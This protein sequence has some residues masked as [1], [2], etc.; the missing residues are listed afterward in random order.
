MVQRDIVGC[1]G[2]IDMKCKGGCLKIHKLLYSCEEKKV[3]NAEQLEKVNAVC[4]KKEECSVQ[5]SREV[6]G[7]KECP[8]A[9]DNEMLM[10]V[11][12]SCDG[13]EDRTKITGPRTCPTG[14]V[15]D[16]TCGEE[17]PMVQQELWI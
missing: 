7:N 11:I 3:S 13:G 9:P 2:E 5:A 4:D 10:W 14:P 6:F 1:G 15:N 12:Y 8:D 17:G 16:K